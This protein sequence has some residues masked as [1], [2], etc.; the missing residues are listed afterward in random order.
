MRANISEL[1]SV[2]YMLEMRTERPAQEGVLS[3]FMD[4]ITS[5]RLTTNEVVGALGVISASTR[6][7]PWFIR[8]SWQPAKEAE[9]H[10]VIGRLCLSEEQSQT[11]LRQFETLATL[12]RSK[13]LDAIAFAMRRYNMAF[14]RENMEDAF[15]DL[16]VAA[17]GILLHGL[18]DELAYRFRIRA[19]ALLK[20]EDPRSVDATLR[21]AYQIRSGLVHGSMS[22]EKSEPGHSKLSGALTRMEVPNMHAAVSTLRGLVGRILSR[23]LDLL[24]RQPNM[25]AVMRYLDQSITTRISKDAP[26]PT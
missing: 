7:Q 12:R 24:L 26:L 1:A 2:R 13:K 14:G 6:P 9:A 18:K 17:E 20:E 22:A 4:V 21:A 10:P 25:E 8:M 15:V 19:L 11:V 3:E 5:I 16:V 23:N